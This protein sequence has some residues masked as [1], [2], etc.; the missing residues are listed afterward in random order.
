[1]TM[2]IIRDNV[3]GDI[4]FSPGEMQILHTA[5][6][7][8]LHGCRQLGLT[9]L[10]YPAAK[11]SRFEH[12]LGVMH[13][14][15]QIIDRLKSEPLFAKEFNE[16]RKV[17]RLAALLH[18]MGHVPFGHTLE[19]EMPV[20]SKHDDA[21]TGATIS[22]MELTVKEVLVEAGQVDY[23]DPV[24]QVLTAIDASKDDAKLYSLVDKGS[25]RPDYVVLADI[26]GNTI[27]A[28]L[29]DYIKRD[30]LM[31]GIRATYDDRIFRY[32]GVGQHRFGDKYYSRIVIRLVKNGRMRGDCLADLFDILKLR[33]N[34]SDKVLFHPQKC[35]AD[36]ML[37]KAVQDLKISAEDLVRYSDDGFLDEFRDEPMIKLIRRRELF[38][39]VFASGLEHITSYDEKSTK[40]DLIR[41]VHQNPTLRSR[42]E[43]AIEGTLGLEAGSVAVFCPRPKMTLKPVRVLVQ[44]KDGTIRR[45]NE[46][47]ETDDPLTAKQ[48]TVLQ[49][50]YPKMWRM[51]LFVRPEI[52]NRGQEIQRVFYESLKKFANLS[53]TCDP[54]LQTYLETACADYRFG[55][56]LDSE[57]GRTAEFLRLNEPERIKVKAKCYRK[58]PLE[59]V[60][61][62]R[63][64]EPVPTPLASRDEEGVKLQQIARKIISAVMSDA[65]K[66][67]KGQLT[68]ENEA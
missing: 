32:F 60:V 59:E 63:Y 15:T 33:Y 27:C 31:T 35:A 47:Q 26:I 67:D 68:L 10:V 40:D 11:H 16:L 30:H 52:R 48:V 65:R 61:D 8:R 20:I 58:L 62:D 5:A 3:H 22:R 17:L 18:D 21:S 49:D 55:K 6:F 29:L 9:H 19:D 50:I 23:A 1:M 25:V 13:V 36:A 57:L 39:P 12:V 43:L 2:K 42:I 66:G 28:D 56:I 54:A 38:K 7:Q 45:L 4:E 64:A 46:I 41:E 34:L 24:L 37:I 51:F 53:A 14:A 44:W